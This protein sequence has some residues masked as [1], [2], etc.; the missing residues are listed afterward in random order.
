MTHLDRLDLSHE[1]LARSQSRRTNLKSCCALGVA[2]LGLGRWSPAALASPVVSMAPPTILRGAD[3]DVTVS[4]LVTLSGI[5]PGVRYEVYGDLM[6][7]D[8]PDGEPDA[9][10]AL[11]PHV[12]LSR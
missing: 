3:C 10:G 5:A 9:C 1:V 11:A 7:S 2:L 4:L 8:D 12:T 6:E